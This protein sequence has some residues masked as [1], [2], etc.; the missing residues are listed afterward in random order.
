MSAQ[1]SVGILTS[2]QLSD[3]VFDWMPLGSRACL[4]NL[5]VKGRS[6]CQLQVYAPNAVS[7]YQAFVHDISNVVQ[8]VGST[9]S[10]ILLVDFNMH[11][12]TDSETWKGVIGRHRDPAFN[13]KGLYLLQ[14][15]CSNR[16]CI[17]NTFFQH[18]DVHKYTWHRPSMA[19]SLR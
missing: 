12:G 14:L 5:T 10:T 15:C 13:E 16:L 6:L 8:R 18:R 9:E 17:M 3:C 2:P 7:K 19:Q 4:L 1:V 11:I